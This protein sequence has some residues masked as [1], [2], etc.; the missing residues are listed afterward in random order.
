MRQNCYMRNE[1]ST[2]K[3]IY[4]LIIFKKSSHRRR[5]R[6]RRFKRSSKHARS[7]INVIFDGDMPALQPLAHPAAPEAPRPI[8]AE[9]LRPN[10][11]YNRLHYYT[12]TTPTLSQPPP[13]QEAPF[14]THSGLL[15][16]RQRSQLTSGLLS[17]RQLPQL[18][19]DTPTHHSQR[20]R[21]ERATDMHAC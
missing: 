9:K 3:Y 11:C 19:S 15:S 14:P 6:R 10:N 17:K 12:I 8:L 5:R 2:L 21:S 4:F 7:C 13:I 20:P 1:I 18:T 16:K